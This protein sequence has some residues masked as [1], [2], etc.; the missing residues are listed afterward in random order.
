MQTMDDLLTKEQA[1]G[2]D[3]IQVQRI[4]VAGEFCKCM[5]IVRCE[6]SLCHRLLGAN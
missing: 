3:G 5:L 4:V 6:Y 1:P 2:E